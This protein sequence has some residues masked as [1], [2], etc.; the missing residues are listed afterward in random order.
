MLSLFTYLTVLYL[1]DLECM[2]SCRIKRREH[3]TVPP[4]G[5][6]GLRTSWCDDRICDKVGIQVG[7]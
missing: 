7:R 5:A 4:R 2:P 1:Y 3:I 6:P